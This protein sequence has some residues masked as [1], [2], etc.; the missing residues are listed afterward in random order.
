VQTLAVGPAEQGEPA[1]CWLVR[2]SA[3]SETPRPPHRGRLITARRG[4]VFRGSVHGSVPSFHPRMSEP[5]RTGAARSGDRPATGAVRHATARLLPHP[6]RGRR[7]LCHRPTHRDPA[8]PDHPRGAGTRSGRPGVGPERA[9]LLPGANQLDIE[10]LKKGRT[11]LI[12]D[13]GGGT[14]CRLCP[15]SA[16]LD[17]GTARM[18]RA[19]VVHGDQSG[20]STAPR[21]KSGTLFRPNRALLCTSM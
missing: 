7:P 11:R 10:A 19:E 4:P 3:R 14:K 2:S 8:S 20:R 17:Q 9:K 12:N 5:A 6:V 16:L 1:L 18:G 21:L 13:I 15:V